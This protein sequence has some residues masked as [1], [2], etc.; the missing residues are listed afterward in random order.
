MVLTIHHSPKGDM[1]TIVGHTY[2]CVYVVVVGKGLHATS[3]VGCGKRHQLPSLSHE[4]GVAFRTAYPELTAAPARY[5]LDGK[6][7]S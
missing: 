1:G 4:G 7:A 2:A 3:G 6:G 5:R